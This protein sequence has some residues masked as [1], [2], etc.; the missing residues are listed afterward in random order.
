MA[1]TAMNIALPT[2]SVR[3]LRMISPAAGCIPNA[4][5]SPVHVT[6]KRTSNALGA[7]NVSRVPALAMT[8]SDVNATL[9]VP[10]AKCVSQAVA[11]MRRKTPG[12][13]THNKTAIRVA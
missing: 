12:T 4:T 1:V 8:R 9:R 11:K 6:A 13:A 2:K 7:S 3:R 5:E 10:D